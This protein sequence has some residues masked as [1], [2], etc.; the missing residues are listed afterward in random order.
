M[1]RSVNYYE[2]LGVERTADERAIKKAYFALVRQ[3]PPETH[4]EEFQRIREAYEVLSNKDARKAYDAVDQ[5]AQYGEQFGAL[6]REASNALD[7]G[8]HDRAQRILLS[9][10]EQKQ[11][12]YAARDMLGMSLLRSQKY[13]A[14]LKEFNRLIQEQPANHLYL[15]HRAY[16]YHAQKKYPQALQSYEGA[17]KINASD[18]ATLVSTADC[19]SAMG[20]YEQA[21]SH[22]DKAILLDGQVDMQDF[23]MLMRKL[24][25]QLLRNRSDLADKEIERIMSILPPND[26]DARKYVASRLASLA[27]DMF[28]LQR[29]A[30]ANRLLKKSREL[31]PKGTHV[32]FP[33]KVK[34]RIDELPEKSQT[35][36]KTVAA[37]PDPYKLKHTAMGW[38]V[39]L[40]ICAIGWL[41]VT[42][43]AAVDSR[44]LWHSDFKT[45]MFIS[46]VLGPLLGAYCIRWIRR[47]QKSPY[48]SFT[49]VHPLYLLQ[50]N[51]DELV[52]WSFANL[53]EVFVTHHSTNG[54]YTN[55][56]VR[57][58]FP[59]TSHSVS[60]RGQ[61]ASV[62]WANHVL[63]RRRRVLELLASGLL[64]GEDG[65]DFIPAEQ[66][67][68]DVARQK[69]ASDYKPL[70]K[71]YGSVAAAGVV[72]FGGAVVFN[73]FAV[74]DEYWYDAT[75][76]PTLSS[77]QQYVDKFPLG[78]HSSEA[79]QQMAAIYDTAIKDF[80]ARAN[81]SRPGVDPMLKVLQALKDTGTTRVKVVFEGTSDFSKATGKGVI[82]PNVAFEAGKKDA[83]EK[84]VA[85]YLNAALAKAISS[86]VMELTTDATYYDSYGVKRTA[87]T[88][89]E[90][91]IK[92]AVTN[93]PTVYRSM[94]GRSSLYGLKFDWDVTFKNKG[95][96]LYSFQ[97]QSESSDRVGQETA[98]YGADSELS[99]YEKIS[100]D[101]FN[102]FARQFAW[103][104]G[105]LVDD[106]L[107]PTTPNP[108]NYA[109]SWD[110]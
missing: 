59:S 76:N 9:V 51:V 32:E 78:K 92:Y 27:A 109:N 29:S 48:K 95:D 19:L 25:I 97:L 81:P 1:N 26:P 35:W 85:N 94:S 55:S 37:D 93:T 82:K 74:E 21:L 30:D 22:L 107:T 2:V 65:H 72:M 16:V 62:D 39:F 20:M 50:V 96:D 64:E 84:E 68:T 52:A 28:A 13:E 57:L 87:E 53:Q 70:L 43:V 106:E 58:K 18:V 69:P 11:D 31:D 40:L 101:A 63:A 47:V 61:Q 66:L 3:Y 71:V 15:L 110:Y 23:S 10:L 33:T 41:F 14:A 105:V 79:K 80:Q 90:M 103:E 88:P 4:P 83:R 102:D 46:C 56:I 17:L 77:L 86:T 73:R 67:R 75:R 42:F 91:H 36:L 34:L 45:F 49:A 100:A 89:I 104:L 24:E 38:P 99:A 12:L 5:Y 7:A 60:I 54:V 6:M 98:R 108:Y 44:R 8:D